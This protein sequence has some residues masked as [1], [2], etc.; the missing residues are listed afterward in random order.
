ALAFDAELS[1]SS[2]KHRPQAA[3]RPGASSRV[4]AHVVVGLQV[5]AAL[6]QPWEQLRSNEV[7]GS[8]ALR[9]RRSLL[10]HASLQ[11]DRDDSRHQVA[12]SAS[13]GPDLTGAET[14]KGAEGHSEP[15]QRPCPEVKRPRSLPKEHPD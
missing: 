3:V 2:P 7:D 5:P 4:R 12:I 14:G 6:L 11:A 1:T 13:Q 8:L 15:E 9:L 10:V